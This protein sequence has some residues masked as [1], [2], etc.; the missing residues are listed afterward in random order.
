MD[1][2][3]FR[4][5]GAREIALWFPVLIF[6]LL[7][8]GAMAWNALFPQEPLMRRGELFIITDFIGMWGVWAILAAGMIGIPILAV[9][10]G[11]WVL[12]ECNRLERMGR[13]PPI[14]TIDPDHDGHNDD[15]QG[16]NRYAYL[17][18]TNND[19]Y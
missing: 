6:G 3:K 8:I 10:H 18:D 7:L 2:T 11:I 17:N 1:V 14:N 9:S 16:V 15:P 13:K 19:N 4:A 12:G 5:Y